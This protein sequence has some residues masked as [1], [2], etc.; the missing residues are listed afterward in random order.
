MKALL[1]EGEYVALPPVHASIDKIV[2]LA[3]GSTEGRIDLELVWFPEALHLAGQR[4][5]RRD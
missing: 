1:E 2:P 4:L 5:P 3:T